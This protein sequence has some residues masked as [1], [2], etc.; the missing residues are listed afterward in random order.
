MELSS[1]FVFVNCIVK[2]KNHSKTTWNFC[3]KILPKNSKK[4]GQMKSTILYHYYGPERKN[5]LCRSFN[6]KHCAL[7]SAIYTLV[8]DCSKNTLFLFSIWFRSL[9]AKNSTEHFDSG[10]AAVL[11]ADKFQHQKIPSTWWCLLWCPDCLLC[12]HRKSTRH[13]G[14]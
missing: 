2:K 3:S 11:V 10:R 1:L 4:T 12:Y 5:G 13:R 7:T 9:T 8:R 6:T 14:A